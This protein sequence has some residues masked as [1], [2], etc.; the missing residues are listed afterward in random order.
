DEYAAGQIDR[1]RYT[2]VLGGGD[3]LVDHR[4]ARRIQRQGERA[5]LHCRAPRDLEALAGSVGADDERDRP[6][7]FLQVLRTVPGIALDDKRRA[8][9]RVLELR[10]DDGLSPEEP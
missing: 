6:E 1:Q 4:R 7:P 8:Y 2:G 9:P 3:R 5:V 10:V